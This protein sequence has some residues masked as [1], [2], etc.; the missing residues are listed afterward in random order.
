LF[1]IN[2]ANV[3]KDVSWI[4]SQQI[5]GVE[6]ND[7][8]E[9]M[10]MI[11]LQGPLSAKVLTKLKVDLRGVERF[12]TR[13]IRLGEISFLLSRTGYTGED[14]FEFFVPWDQTKALWEKLFET[15]QEFGMAP[16]GLGARD[17]LR[18]EMGYVLYGHELNE[19]ISPLEAGLNWV[20][21]WEKGD[22]IGRQALV[23]QRE[24]GIS[25]KLVGLKMEENGIPR[26]G[27]A[28]HGGGHEIGR[29]CSGTMSPVLKQGIATALVEKKLIPASG[30]IFVDI[31]GKMKKAKIIRAPFIHKN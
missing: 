21:A 26:E 27:M 30:E 17:T 5:P 18:L 2:A 23:E 19:A 25:R 6:I 4:R 16:I 8:S 7:A 1:C 13:E 14:G 28:I 15:G 9:R 24:R 12:M 11:A 29:V 31:R 10:G 3:T 20:I 22:F